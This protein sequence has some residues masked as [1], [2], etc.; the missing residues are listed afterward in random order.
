MTAIARLILKDG[1]SGRLPFRAETS[2]VSEDRRMVGV[3]TQTGLLLIL[4]VGLIFFL[5]E[6][7][8]FGWWK[9]KG[10]SVHARAGRRN[11]AGEERQVCISEAERNYRAS[12]DLLQAEC[13]GGI[14]RNL[15]SRLG[16][17]SGHKQVSRDAP[18]SSVVIE[19]NLNNTGEHCVLPLQGDRCIELTGLIGR[20]R[21]RRCSGSPSGE[22]F[23]GQACQKKLIRAPDSTLMRE[24]VPGRRRNSGSRA[25]LGL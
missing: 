1:F 14:C 15:D 18:K 21:G 6:L 12:S 5:F 23:G 3:D 24:D 2:D 25:E 19:K 16:A 4:L 20:T 17:I 22:I 7:V 8:E 11:P 10:H 13:Q 9:L